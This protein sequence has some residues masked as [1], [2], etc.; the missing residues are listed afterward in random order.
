MYNYGLCVLLFL[1]FSYILNSVYF[2]LFVIEMM[3]VGFLIV[4]LMIFVV[5]GFFMMI[6]SI[7]KFCLC[8]CRWNQL[9]GRLM[10]LEL[11]NW[12]KDQLLLLFFVYIDFLFE[13]EFFINMEEIIY[14]LKLNY[15]EN[16]MQK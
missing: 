11:G 6:F 1:F 14:N 10:V 7:F 2:I 12:S 16:Y 15:M 3:G 5:G 4:F 9:F 8:V 13:E